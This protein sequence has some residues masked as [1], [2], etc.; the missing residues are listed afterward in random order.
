MNKYTFKRLQNKL[1]KNGVK[2]ER[3]NSNIIHVE[4][5]N[6]YGLKS[7]ILLPESFQIEEKAINQLLDFS[8][9]S[10]PDGGHVKCSC[11]TPDF[12]SGT[13][14]PVGSVVVTDHSMV[15][16]QAI[17]TD[18]NCGMR[19]HKIDL[20]YDK[21]LE[22]K[23]FWIEKLKGDLLGGTRNVPVTPISMTSL[24]NE[25]IGAFFDEIKNK[26]EG[27]FKN[28]DYGLIQKELKK[29]HI[30]AFENGNSIYA[31]DSLQKISRDLIRDP[32][33][34]T[35]GGGN[36]FCE[37]QVVTEIID[38][39]KAY[40]NGLKVGQLVL[41]IHTGS[42]D[43][44]FYVGNRWKDKAKDFWP[45]NLKYPDNK[46]F[47]LYGKLANEYMLAMYSASHYAYLNRALIAEIVRQRTIEVFGE[48]DCSLI[49]DVP[50]NIILKED[51]G[52]VHRKGATPAFKD[53]KL[54]IPGSMGHDSY[55]LNGLGNSNWLKSAS[56]GAGRNISRTEI[57]FKSK[58]KKFDLG[59]KNIEC[60]TL[61]EERII[62]ECPAAYKEIGPV[63]SSQVEEKV[64]DVIAKF[65]PILTFKS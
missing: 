27:L 44:G 60:I 17:G 13:D 49:V 9:I 48:I 1:Q 56:H 64:I 62:E 15:I 65:S 10:H 46:I 4:S 63:I 59:L 25:G 54:L 28:I 43:V 2:I 32:S 47:P 38:K 37:L 26:K 45:K 11:A 23:S 3:Y 51:I 29:L 61:N 33:L 22:K 58:N 35:L 7:K 55:L 50:H 6:T 19:L 53:Q 39:Q 42:R 34:A 41:M 16:P 20:T 21:F 40:L 57:L 12:H 24:F 8:R 14:I 30:S 36:H 52:N 18:I 31:P 5:L